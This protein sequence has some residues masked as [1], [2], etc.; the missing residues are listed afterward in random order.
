MSNTI[1]PALLFKSIIQP[2]A[3][4]ESLADSEPAPVKIFTRYSM[5]L[6]ML[7]PLFSWIGAY[8]FGW[9]LGADEPLQLTTTTLTVISLGYFL[10]LLFGFVTTAIISRWMAVTYGANTNPGLHA[11]LITIV[12]QPLALA[13]AAHLFPDVFFNL[14]VMI[15]VTIWSM[16]LLYTGIPIV[17]SIPPERGMLMASSLVG[18]LLVAVVSLLGLTVGLWTT[19]FGPLLGV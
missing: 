12:G 1:S 16:Y 9:R 10:T 18:W 19:G 5:W 14:I 17:L 4:F 7:P 2:K 13:S 15:P 8:S 11:A 6:L 3:V